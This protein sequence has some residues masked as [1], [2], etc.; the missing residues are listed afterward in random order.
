MRIVFDELA[1]EE[2]NDG[3]EYYEMELENLAMVNQQYG[4]IRSTYN[5]DINMEHIEAGII[6]FTAWRLIKPYLDVSKQFKLSRVS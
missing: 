3:I 4:N 5:R 6:S 1:E 2:L